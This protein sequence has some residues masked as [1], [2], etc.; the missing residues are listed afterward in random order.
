M[1]FLSQTSLKVKYVTN[2]CDRRNMSVCSPV[3]SE[4]VKWTSQQNL[5]SCHLSSSYT[6]FTFTNAFFAL[7]HNDDAKMCLLA[8]LCLCVPTSYSLRTADQIFTEWRVLPKFDS[9]FQH[10]LQLRKNNRHFMWRLHVTL[11]NIYIRKKS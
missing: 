2:K 7:I 9:T 4:M 3:T 10:C 11:L 5:Q 1:S 6:L 8:S